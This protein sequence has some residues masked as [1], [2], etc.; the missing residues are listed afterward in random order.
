MFFS[1]SFRNT[2][3]YKKLAKFK[4][5]AGN[6]KVPKF[7]K[8]QKSPKNSS[9]FVCELEKFH[10]VAPRFWRLDISVKILSSKILKNSQNPLSFPQNS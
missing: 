3:I 8:I 6:V 9:S 1:D 4:S 10:V 7:L 5:Y 2:K